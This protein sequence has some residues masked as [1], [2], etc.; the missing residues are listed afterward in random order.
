MVKLGFHIKLHTAG[1]LLAFHLQNKDF[2]RKIQKIVKVDTLFQ[3]Q[4]FK[5]VF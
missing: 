2:G 3:M 1:I 4:K 5:T